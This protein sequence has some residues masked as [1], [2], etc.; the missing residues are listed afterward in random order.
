MIAIGIKILLFVTATF[1]VLRLIKHPRIA[2]PMKMKIN[3][4][5]QLVIMSTNEKIPALDASQFVTPLVFSKKHP[6]AVVSIKKTI[7]ITK[8]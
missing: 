8:P 4:T 1:L 6:I 2:T 3:N 5:S 7:A